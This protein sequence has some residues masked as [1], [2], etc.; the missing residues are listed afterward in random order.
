MEMVI[1]DQGGKNFCLRDPD[2]TKGLAEEELL[3]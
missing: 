2:F 3:E 1:E